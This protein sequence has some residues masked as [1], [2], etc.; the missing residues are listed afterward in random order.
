MDTS[1]SPSI[2]AESGGTYEVAFEANNNDLYLVQ[3]SRGTVITGSNINTQL[4]ML[5]GTRP[6]IAAPY[7]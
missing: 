7:L 1:S 6:S 4:G 3:A 5:S 2:A